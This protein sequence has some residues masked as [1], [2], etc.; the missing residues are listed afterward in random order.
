MGAASLPA[1]QYCATISQA[2]RAPGPRALKS[3]RWTLG[4]RT[5]QG[6]LEKQGFSQDGALQLYSAEALTPTR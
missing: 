3:C 2:R 5:G 4:N 6:A 1:A